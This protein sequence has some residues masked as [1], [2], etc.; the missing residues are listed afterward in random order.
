MQEDC[1]SLGVKDKP[2]QQSETPFLFIK[3]KLIKPLRWLES[4]LPVTSLE[5]FPSIPF[6]PLATKGQCHIPTLPMRASFPSLAERD[7]HHERWALC[8][9]CSAP[10]L[11][12]LRPSLQTKASQGTTVCLCH[13]VMVKRSIGHTRYQQHGTR[14]LDSHSAPSV[15]LE[16]EM[17]TVAMPHSK[18]I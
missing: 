6:P 8:W 11:L 14:A 3:K 2:W 4:K 16:Q 12:Q 10:S 15:S 1:M 18:V 5:D 9:T 17:L 7:G 13:K